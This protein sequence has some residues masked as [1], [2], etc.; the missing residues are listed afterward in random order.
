MENIAMSILESLTLS[1]S[2]KRTENA[3]PKIALRRKMVA[4]LDHQINAA[5]AEIKGETYTITVEKWVETDKATGTKE[6]R[7]VAKA[8]RRMWYVAGADRVM[9][10]LR[11][12]NKP[13]SVGGKASIVVGTMDKLVPTLQTVRKAVMA[14]ELDVALKAASDGRKRSLKLITA[15]ANKAPKSLK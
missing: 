7:K 5:T 15:A 8:L 13:I 6:R 2:T 4:A 9:V 1:D 14:G 3:D 10:E 12:A 11:F